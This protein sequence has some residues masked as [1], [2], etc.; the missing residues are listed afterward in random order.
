MNPS[1]EICLVLFEDTAM[2]IA[3]SNCSDLIALLP[4]IFPRWPF[5]IIAMDADGVEPFL[6]ITKNTSGYCLSSQFMD[7]PKTYKDVLDTICTM[8]V[9]IAWR[10]FATIQIGFVYIAQPLSFRVDW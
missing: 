3:L 8:L 10:R 5:N 1:D 7:K 4:D 2:L 9:E 6:T